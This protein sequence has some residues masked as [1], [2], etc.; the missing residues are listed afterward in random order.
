MVPKLWEITFRI[1]IIFLQYWP[2]IKIPVL[3]NIAVSDENKNNIQ[4]INNCIDLRGTQWIGH[5]NTTLNSNVADTR[6]NHTRQYKTVIL[7]FSLLYLEPGLWPLWWPYHY[8]RIHRREKRT[9]RLWSQDSASHE[10]Q[11]QLEWWTE[12]HAEKGIHRAAPIRSL[13]TVGPDWGG[14]QWSAARPL[15]LVRRPSLWGVI[16]AK[17]LEW[18]ALWHDEAAVTPCWSALCFGQHVSKLEWKWEICEEEPHLY[19][20]LFFYINKVKAFLSNGTNMHVFRERMT[21]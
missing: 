5:I 6:S 12:A 13:T 8:A 20:R 2:G 15:S 7:Y 4:V 19:C 14:P 18:N 9:L 21:W 16:R 3:N 11:Q 10:S 17:L 1:E